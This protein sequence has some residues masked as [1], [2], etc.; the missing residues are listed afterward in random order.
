VPVNA[1]VFDTSVAPTI[2]YSADPQGIGARALRERG[3]DVSTVRAE[4][5]RLDVSELV[6]DL[7]RRGF[8]SLLVEGGGEVHASLLAGHHAHRI[9]FFYAPLLLGGEKARRAVAGDGFGLVLPH[10]VLTDLAWKRLGPDR[11]LT[12]RI[13]PP[14][15]R[16]ATIPSPKP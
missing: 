4:G 2:V 10:P 3:V 14:S 15:D 7:G 1:K 8:S 11:L 6:R 13:V 12:A 5:E 16:P 9:A